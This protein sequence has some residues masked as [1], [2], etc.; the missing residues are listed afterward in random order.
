MIGGEFTA[1][2]VVA[3]TFDLGLPRNRSVPSLAPEYRALTPRCRYCNPSADQTGRPVS[4]AE[5]WLPLPLKGSPSIHQSL[6]LSGKP[7]L[8]GD[9][10]RPHQRWMA[11]THQ[12]HFPDRDTGEDAHGGIAGVALYP[13]NGYGLHDMAGN[14]WQWVSDWYRPDYYAQLAAAQTVARNPRGPDSSLDPAEPREKKRVQRGGSYLCTDQYCSRY[15]VGTRGKGDIKTGTN[16]LGFRCVR[17]IDVS[18]SLR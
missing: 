1:V 13:P 17:S 18:A 2:E 15:M 12:G 6:N 11:N 4:L 16:H 5:N 7:F 14:I 3:E 8:W 10:F 9:E